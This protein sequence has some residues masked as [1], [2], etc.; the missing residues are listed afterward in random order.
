MT[1][2]GLRDAIEEAMFKL[3]V[4][5]DEKWGIIALH[6]AYHRDHRGAAAAAR[7]AHRAAQRTGIARLRQ[8]GGDNEEFQA[9]STSSSGRCCREIQA[10]DRPAEA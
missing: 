8:V 2:A 6:R 9:W 3:P 1:T 5:D 4:G 7:E 10:A